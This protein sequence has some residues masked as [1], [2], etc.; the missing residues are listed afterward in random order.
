MSSCFIVIS[1]SKEEV[2][3]DEILFNSPEKEQGE[4]LI[5]DGDPEV[6]EPCIFGKG[7]YFSVS[8]CLCC[9]KDIYIYV[10]GMGA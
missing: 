4:F 7:I 6:L 2:D 10:G 1:S 5:I 9:V 8:Y 3:M